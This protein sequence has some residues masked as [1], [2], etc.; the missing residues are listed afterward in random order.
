[1]L[2]QAGNLA[3]AVVRSIASGLARATP[4]RKAERM[5][6]CNGCEQFAEGR[7]KLCGCRLTYKV[8]MA[9]EACPIDKW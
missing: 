6:I 2:E 9:T 1:L 8:G 7:C 3:G 5:A 4:E